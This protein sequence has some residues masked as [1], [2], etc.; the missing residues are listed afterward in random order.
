MDK[1]P[2]E[3]ALAADSKYFDGLLVTATSIALFANPQATLSY[4][5]LDGGLSAQEYAELKSYV[6]R[7]H[8]PSTFNLIKLNLGDFSVADSYAGGKMPYARLLLPRLLSGSEFVIYSDVDTLWLTDISQLWSLRDRNC[9][10][11]SSPEKCAGTLDMEAKWFRDR[12]LAFD[13]ASYFCTGLSFMNLRLFRDQDICGKCLDFLTLHGH[14]NCADQ[15]ALNA[16]LRNSARLLP[17]CWQKFPRNG[18]SGKDFSGTMILHYAGEVPWHATR[19]THLLTDIQLLWF[20]F[21][22]RVAR[23]SV[24]QS[25]RKHYSATQ[26]ISGRLLFLLIS[27]IVGRYLFCNFLRHTGRGTFDERLPAKAKKAFLQY[28]ANGA[29]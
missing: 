10:Y 26:I 18:I 3:I 17:D 16:I 5:I 1:D 23:K 8:T 21:Y 28:L 13:Q 14:T 7:I 2:V 9:I 27:T 24:W 11:M 20:K 19:Q 25:L 15:T 12:G 22:A 6:M 4:T 29:L